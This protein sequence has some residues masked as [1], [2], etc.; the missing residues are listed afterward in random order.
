MFKRSRVRRL[1]AVLGGI[2]VLV[3][4]CGD[5]ANQEVD[6]GAETEAPPRSEVTLDFSHSYET[7]HPFHVCGAERV[8]EELAIADVGLD[9]DLFPASQLG[10]EA[11]RFELAIEGELDVNTMGPGHVGRFF[12]AVGALDAVF[13]FDDADHLEEVMAGSIGD[14]LRA[15]IL[16]ETGQRVLGVWFFGERHFT[17]NTPIRHPDDLQGLRMRYPDNEIYIQNAKTFGADPTPVSFEEVYTALQQGVVDGQENPVP[18]ISAGGFDEVQD[19]ISLSA[20]QVSPILVTIPETTF[21]ELASDQQE[22]L[23]AAIVSAG[24]EV[25]TCVEDEEQEILDEWR[26][27]DAGIQVIEDVDRDAFIQLAEERRGDLFEDDEQRDLYERIR[28]TSTR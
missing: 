18:T 12:A 9:L 2:A 27:D 15:G 4:A 8:E 25:R 28:A 26:A 3:A 7:E 23:A 10:E 16:E 21:Q 1:T 6:Q 19:Y 17:A 13:I 5:E 11:E 24:Q 22:A 14:E 20:H